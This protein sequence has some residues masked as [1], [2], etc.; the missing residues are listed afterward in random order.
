[1][2]VSDSHNDLS[3]VEL[4]HVLR[5]SLPRLEYFVELASSDEGHDEVESQLRL[6][7]VVHAHQEG[8]VARKENVLLQLG[9]VHLIELQQDVLPYRLDSVKVG[10]LLRLKFS[11]VYLAECASAQHCNQLEILKLNSSVLPCVN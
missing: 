1:M 6:E 8:V 4:N 5:E 3:S 11:Q 2:Q 7:Q 10:R 9:I